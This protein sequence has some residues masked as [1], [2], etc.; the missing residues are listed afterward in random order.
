MEPEKGPSVVSAGGPFIFLVLKFLLTLLKMVI[1]LAGDS[2]SVTIFSYWGGTVQQE[3]FDRKRLVN[4][5]TKF[6]REQNGGK[7]QSESPDS[8]HLGWSESGCLD[9]YIKLYESTGDEKWLRKMTSHFDRMLR[10]RQDH[11][12]DGSP[13]WVTPTYSVALVHTGKMHNRGTAQITPVE[14]RVW[15]I[16]GGASI[17]DGRWILEVKDGGGFVVHDYGTRR[18]AAKGKFR[19]GADIP[20]FSPFKISIAGKPMPGDRFWVQMFEG[21]P[22]EYIVHQGMFLY[23][24]SRFIETVLKNRDLKAKY[25]EKAGKYLKFIAEEIADKHERDWVDTSRSTGGY[26]FSPWMTERF[27]NRIMPHNQYLALGRAY[28]M[29]GNVSRKRLFADRTERMARNF[30]KHLRKTGNAYTWYYWDWLE[31]GDPGNSNVE[32]TSHG[33][34]DIGFVVDAC[35]R[36]VVFTP[37][38]LKRFGRT[39]LDQMWNGSLE[40]PVIGGHVDRKEGDAK[41]VRDWIDL[42]Q[43]TPDVWDVMFASFCKQGQPVSHIPS[44]LQGWSRFHEGRKKK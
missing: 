11:F 7:G 43:W 2:I 32:D 22:L 13:T 5:Y 4:E 26:R 8:G 38:D 19:S 10:T 40:D 31:A 21:E 30:K 36:G 23:P 6:D 18:Q 16:R 3:P 25:G 34:I 35:R 39:L 37:G 24:M 42:C 33:Q 29:L 1:G 14:D 28:L 44:I 41:P 27:P 20:F 15:T 12:E 9:A 17:G